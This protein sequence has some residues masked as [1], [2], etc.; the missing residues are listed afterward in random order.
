MARKFQATPTQIVFF[1]S[2]MKQRKS[3]VNFSHP[4]GEQLGQ[5]ASFA[6]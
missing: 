3:E 2:S 4:N 5:M 6:G 1:R